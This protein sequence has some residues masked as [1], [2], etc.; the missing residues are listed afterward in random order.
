MSN[1]I[2]KGGENM[3][4]NYANAK[5]EL[6]KILIKM[7]SQTERMERSEKLSKKEETE[8]ETEFMRAFNK[9]LNIARGSCA[10]VRSMLYL[11]LDLGYCSKEQHD[12]LQAQLV[13]ISSGIFKLI[14]YLKKA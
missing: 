3:Q 10:E 13:L 5:K 7:S 4:S 14:E 9:F 11:S 12:K 8:T 2:L 1:V 6:D